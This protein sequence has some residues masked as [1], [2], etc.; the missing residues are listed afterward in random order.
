M[1]DYERL[2]EKG[3]KYFI[4]ED[5]PNNAIV[6]LKGNFEEIVLNNMDND[7]LCDKLNRLADLEDKI[8]RGEI[9]Y[10]ADKDKEIA[11]L[12]EENE[13]LKEE[14]EE[15]KSIAEHEHA[16]Q[17]DWFNT[18]CEYK[19]EN[20]D[21]HARLEKAVETPVK[22]GDTVYYLIGFSTI[23]E[24][25]VQEIRLKADGKYF[26]IC[27]HEG[28]DDYCGMSSEHFGIVWFTDRAEAEL[29]GGEGE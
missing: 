27:G 25:T 16:T 6:L 29:K 8:E 26:L 11:R 10:V 13:R 1:K 22:I 14:A 15:Q 23:Q 3:S 20:A 5:S 7:D 17:M 21:L 19:A 9:D 18:A 28:T 12:T 4:P 24:W 2:T